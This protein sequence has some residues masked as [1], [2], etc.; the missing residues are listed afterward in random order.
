MR[1]AT[2]EIRNGV[3]GTSR[4]I[5]EL[6]EMQCGN[7]ED[8]R[9]KATQLSLF[10]LI[11]SEEST[12][13]IAPVISSAAPVVETTLVA[14]PTGLCGL[15]P[16]N[17]Y[18]STY[19][20]HEF[21]N[22]PVYCP[23]R[24]FIDDQRLYPTGGLPFLLVDLT[25]PSQLGRIS[26]CLQGRRVRPLP[27]RR[28]GIEALHHPLLSSHHSSLQF[29]LR[30][31]FDQFIFFGFGCARSGLRDLR[32]E[33]YH[34]PRRAPRR[35]DSSERPMHSSPHSAG[36]SRKRC[37]SPVDSVSL[38]M[39]VTGSLA[40]T[41]ADH[42]HIRTGV[43]MELGIGDRDEVGDRVGIDHRDATDDTEEYEADAST[44]DTTEAGI[45]PMTAALVEEEIVEPAGEDSP[46]SPDTRDGIVRSVE[47]TPVDLSDAGGME[48]NQ[49]I[50]SGDRVRMAGH[51]SLWLENLQKIRAMLDIERDSE[52]SIRLHMSLLTRRSFVRFVGDG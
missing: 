22:A 39:P 52:S 20:Q 34:P 18:S 16:F 32:L 6:W 1:V 46:D 50:A 12:S 45:D 29:I 26:C 48:A 5:F 21:P 44:G 27:A 7:L 10:L 33:M 42:L 25:A 2:I 31:L 30:I 38:S 40:P 14:S 4:T 8:V 3:S 36:P 41:R 13:T 24:G 15:V 11:S 17:R 51:Y 23:S 19:H 43:D 28:L 35:R 49:L 37:R 9:F 47:D